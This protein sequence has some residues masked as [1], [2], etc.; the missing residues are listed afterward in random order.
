[1]YNLGYMYQDVA[2]YLKLA[3]D[4]VEYWKYIGVYLGDFLIRFWWR[5]DFNIT[6]RYDTVEACYEDLEDCDED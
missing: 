5:K 1:L 2:N 4:T 3:D 6:F